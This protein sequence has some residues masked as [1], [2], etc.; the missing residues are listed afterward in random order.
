MN[1]VEIAR[2]LYFDY[3]SGSSIILPNFAPIG[4][5]ECDVFRVTTAGYFYEYEIKTSLSD[6]KAENQKRAYCSKTSSWRYKGEMTKSATEYAPSRFFYVVPEGLSDKIAPILPEWA[7]L[8]ELSG[9]LRVVR[10]APILHKRKIKSHRVRD[11]QRRVV[12]RY[13]DM[14]LTFPDARYR[15]Y[16]ESRTPEVKN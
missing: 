7:G 16:L 10:Q 14:W 6:F 9:H 4:W 3:V 5:F 11:L 1:A 12:G 15:R 8:I 13:W 2:R